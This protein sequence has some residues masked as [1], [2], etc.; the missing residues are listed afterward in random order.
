MGTAMIKKLKQSLALAALLAAMPMAAH[1]TE[2]WYGRADVGYSVDGHVTLDD[3]DFDL[4]DDWMADVG[5]GY[6]FQNGFRAE[7]ELAYRTNE[8]P[9]FDEDAETWSLMA[10]LF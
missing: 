1:A 6:G 3:T 8:Q 9:D 4:D 5:V 7:G 10:N 2:G